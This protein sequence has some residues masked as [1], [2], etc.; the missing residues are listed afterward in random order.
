MIVMLL[1][2]IIVS[3]LM[4]KQMGYLELNEDKIE[5]IKKKPQE[6]IEKFKEELNKAQEK[7]KE[8]YQDD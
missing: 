5:S 8:R 6:K 2:L 1:T 4:L 3:I 7:M